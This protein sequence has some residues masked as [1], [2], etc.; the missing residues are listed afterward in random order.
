M[1]VSRTVSYCCCYSFNEC[2][3]SFEYCPGYVRLKIFFNIKHVD[4]R[5]Y[6][7]GENDKSMPILNKNTVIVDDP[8]YT[9]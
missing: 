1:S 2:L 9:K 3:L 4:L 7:A 8:S 6:N 5:C